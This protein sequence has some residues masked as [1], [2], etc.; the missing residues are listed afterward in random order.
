VTSA[1]EVGLGAAWVTE[2][3]RVHT[4]DL[5]GAQVIWTGAHV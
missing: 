2:D 4:N 5:I 1:L 3:G